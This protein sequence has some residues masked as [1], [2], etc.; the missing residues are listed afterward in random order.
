MNGPAPIDRRHFLIGLLSATGGCTAFQARR[1]VLPE[2]NA[3]TYDQLVIHSDLQLPSTHRLLEDLRILRSDVLQK[4][5]LPASDEPIHVY[6]F[7][8]EQQFEEFMRR[9]YPNFPTRRAFFV[10]SDTRLAVYAFWGDRVAEDL[11]H[12]TTHGY[13]H[14]VVRHIPL[15]LDEG[16]AEYF[17][18]PRG[19]KGINSPHAEQL[20]TLLM[21]QGWRPNLS[22]LETLTSVREMK[23]EDYAESWAWMHWMIESDPALRLL[24]QQHLASIRAGTIYIPLSV[25]IK[26]QR[27]D[28]EHQLCEHLFALAGRR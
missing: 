11:R 19:S 18:V 3:V 21:T 8:T 4:L 14:S 6:L 5:S 22:R 26:S 13:L 17:E 7:E 2:R 12:E 27:I 28:S 15:W 23:Q 1:E 24:L 20:L 25:A 10:E 9:T 16:L